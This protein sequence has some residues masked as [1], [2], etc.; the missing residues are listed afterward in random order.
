MEAKLLISVDF[1][2]V[3]DGIYDFQKEM[4]EYLAII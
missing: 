3:H 4:F 1:S 2:F